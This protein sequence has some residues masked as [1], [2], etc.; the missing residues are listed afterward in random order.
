MQDEALWGGAAGVERKIGGAVM[1]LKARRFGAIDGPDEN[2]LRRS[3]KRILLFLFR[4]VNLMCAE[5]PPCEPPNTPK[6]CIATFDTPLHLAELGHA[7][8][9]DVLLPMAAVFR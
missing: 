3:N 6:C 9:P 2:V 8:A 1:P 7:M 4:F 5:T